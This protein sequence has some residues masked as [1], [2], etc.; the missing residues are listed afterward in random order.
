MVLRSTREM[1][2]IIS[3]L[4]ELISKLLPPAFWRLSYLARTKIELIPLTLPEGEDNTE[5]NLD[6]VVCLPPPP[7][8]TDL[9]TREGPWRLPSFGWF[10]GHVL[11]TLQYDPTNP[12]ELSKPYAPLLIYHRRPRPVYKRQPILIPGRTTS[13][14][15]C[16]ADGFPPR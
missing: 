8:S 4:G 9:G 13:I 14:T 3:E 15:A 1:S 6:D 7:Q 12:Q 10:M 2:Y 11:D 5:D 16:F